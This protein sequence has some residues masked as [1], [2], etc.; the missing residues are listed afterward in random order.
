V[1]RAQPNNICRVPLSSC[2]RVVAS[3]CFLHAEWGTE[4]HSDLR[5]SPANWSA[6]A[7]YQALPTVKQCG[8]LQAKSGSCN[9]W[10]PSFQLARWQAARFLYAS[11]FKGWG[12][13]SRAPVAD[14][15]ERRQVNTPSFERM[16]RARCNFGALECSRPV[17]AY[18]EAWFHKESRFRSIC[19]SKLQT[20]EQ[21][22]H[23]LG[24]IG[25]LSRS[26]G[27]KSGKTFNR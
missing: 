9:S 5:L 19:P 14:T 24:N 2:W 10:P 16:T 22:F 21:I 4:V 11:L 17:V 12:L 6:G 27:R 3:V 18:Q 23:E 20:V 25:F 26:G 13:K 8:A 7:Q 15:F 1:T